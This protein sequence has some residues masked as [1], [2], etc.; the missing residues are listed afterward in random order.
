M[1]AIYTSVWDDSEVIDTLCNYEPKT[2][3]VSNVEQSENIDELDICVLTDEYITL[4]NGEIIQRED[5]LLENE[6][7]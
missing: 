5:F 3:K 4:P 6:D 7:Y 2:K 1:K